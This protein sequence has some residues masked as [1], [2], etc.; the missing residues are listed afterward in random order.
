[1]KCSQAYG[2]EKCCANCTDWQKA[3]C[4]HFGKCDFLADQAAEINELDDDGNALIMS[5]VDCLADDP[6]LFFPT[7]Y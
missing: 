2:W 3:R 5:C 6:Y 4:K 7:S 1:M